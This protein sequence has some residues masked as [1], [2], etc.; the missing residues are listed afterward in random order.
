MDNRGLKTIIYIVIGVLV[1]GFIFRV[2]PYLVLGGVVAY[3][4]YKGYKFIANKFG[5]KNNTK[6]NENTYTNVSGDVNISDD[7][8]IS[9]AIDVDYKDV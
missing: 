7:E 2:L 1:V 8:D 6:F 5:N 4:A 9:Q 3:G